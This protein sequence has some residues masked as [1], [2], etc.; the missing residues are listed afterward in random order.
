MYV[1]HSLALLPLPQSQISPA[2]VPPSLSD[3]F[4]LLPLS[5]YCEALPQQAP[6]QLK[7][8]FSVSLLAVLLVSPRSQARIDFFFFALTHF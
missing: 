1:A 7:P 6:W 5:L 8:K 3:K 2:P 4:S